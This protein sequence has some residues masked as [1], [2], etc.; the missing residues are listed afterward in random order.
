MGGGGVLQFSPS[1]THALVTKVA[2]RS[3]GDIL[4]TSTIRESIDA[5]FIVF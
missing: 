1:P 4:P 2:I 3:E 5:S